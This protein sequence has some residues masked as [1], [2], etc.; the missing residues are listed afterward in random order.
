VA[1]EAETE[2]LYRI[3]YAERREPARLAPPEV[4]RVETAAALSVHS[5][6]GVAPV[7]TAP[8][9]QIVGREAEL[10]QLQGALAKTLSGERQI[11]FLT[12]EAGIGKTTLI[13]MF[14]AEVAEQAPSVLRACCIEHFGQ[15]EALL[16]L[17]EAIEHQCRLERGASLIGCLRRHAPVWLAQLPSVLTSEE[18]E[19]LQREILGASR[20]RMLREGCVLL[21]E[22]CGATP[23]VLVVEDLH[24]SDH[25]ML[26]FL[27]LLAQRNLPARLLALVS[28]RPGD[29]DFHTHPVTRCS[30]ANTLI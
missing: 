17:I 19:A 13:E 11:A 7:A 12:G 27:A 22:L 14:L 15:G 29:A 2:A 28:Y 25:A 5:L 6:P 21:E 24:W 10:K 26:G 9:A 18:R 20:E 16:P 23:L 8:P 4:P 3:L 1:P 30:S